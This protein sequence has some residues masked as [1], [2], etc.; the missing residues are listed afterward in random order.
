MTKVLTFTSIF[1]AILSNIFADAEFFLELA[2]IL[3]WQVHNVQIRSLWR[4]ELVSFAKKFFNSK[5]NPLLKVYEK[6]IPGTNFIGKEFGIGFSLF[7]PRFHICIESPLTKSQLLKNKWNYW[8]ETFRK[9]VKL[10]LILW[11]ILADLIPVILIRTKHCTDALNPINIAK[12]IHEGI[13]Q[14]YP[15]TSF[16]GHSFLVLGIFNIC[17]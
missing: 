12:S 8:S 11:K 15:I 2:I 1:H 17:S 16:M 3:S 9:C 5:L 10:I 13:Y 4:Y 6:W 14:S 7:E